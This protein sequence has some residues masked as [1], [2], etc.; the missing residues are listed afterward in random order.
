MR[1]DLEESKLSYEASGRRRVMLGVSE[2][3]KDSDAPRWIILHPRMKRPFRLAFNSNASWHERVPRGTSV[4]FRATS[5][6]LTL[7]RGGRVAPS[8]CLLFI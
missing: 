6:R 7:C 3:P 1:E 4:A 5:T 2:R 8:C